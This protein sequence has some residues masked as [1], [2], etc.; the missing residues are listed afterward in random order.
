MKHLKIQKNVTLYN[1]KPKNNV[2]KNVAC[3]CKKIKNN[4]T[5]IS[6]YYIEGDYLC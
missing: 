1:S 3:P 4:V 2:A 6:V 5:L